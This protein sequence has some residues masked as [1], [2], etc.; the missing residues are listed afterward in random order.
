MVGTSR[1]SGFARYHQIL[2]DD[3][4]TEAL[5]GRHRLIRLLTKLEHEIRLARH[6]AAHR[7]ADHALVIDQQHAD[8]VRHREFRGGV[9]HEVTNGLK[10]ELS[11]VAM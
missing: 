11:W 1:V 2:Q 7:L 5:C 8:F 9:S 10:I 4:R 3:G 6:H